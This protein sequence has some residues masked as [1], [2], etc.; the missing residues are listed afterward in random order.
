M[1]ESLGGFG[2]MGEYARRLCWNGDISVALEH[3]SQP[4]LPP[5]WAPPPVSTSE[6]DQM[7]LEGISALG[8][9]MGSAFQLHRH[10]LSPGL[11]G[12][13]ADICSNVKL[14]KLA[15]KQEFNFTTQMVFERGAA[16]L[17]RLL[18]GG[19]DSEGQ[20]DLLSLKQ[21]CCRYALALWVWNIFIRGAANIGVDMDYTAS[22]DV[23]DARQ[24][25]PIIARQLM[26]TIF[27]ACEYASECTI[28]LTKYRLFLWIIGVGISGAEPGKGKDWYID[29]F[30][31]LAN[32][33]EI[34]TIE[35]VSRVFS[36]YLYVEEFECGNM[37]RLAELLSRQPYKEPR[38]SPV[39][40]RK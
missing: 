39:R 38:T 6:Q 3:P 28:D 13:V 22:T 32:V 21:D 4:I 30:W 27:R 29:I 40:A 8:D 9:G 12:I 20:R 23:T 24:M 11:L 37:K 35:Q 33:L 36:G 14:L 31:Q 10:F 26:Q 16:L 15:K 25:R 17:H 2:H 18:S 7:V 1:V 34:S 19:P 5:I